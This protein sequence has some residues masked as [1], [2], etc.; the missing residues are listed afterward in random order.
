MLPPQRKCGF[1]LRGQLSYICD[2]GKHYVLRNS[3][4][5]SRNIVKTLGL[6]ISVRGYTGLY[7]VVLN[8]RGEIVEFD[9]SILENQEPA[10]V[11][12]LPENDS[13]FIR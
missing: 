3:S 8:L 12:K 2:L 4:A 7:T 10:E 6:T 9:I 13:Y 5:H 1:P 11:Q